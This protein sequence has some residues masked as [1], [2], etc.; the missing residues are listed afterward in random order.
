MRTH[1]D[2][3]TVGFGDADPA[4]IVFY[5]RLIGLAHAAVENL[6]R[7]S[8]LGWEAWFSSRTHAAPIRRVEAEFF[9]PVAAGEVLRTRTKVEKIGTTS[10]TFSVEFSRLSGPIAARVVSVHVLIDRTTGRKA[11]LTDEMQQT[12]RERAG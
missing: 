5:P 3:I 8:P 9:G 11:A 4:G 7:H 1:D 12:F 10:V 2:Q 6:I